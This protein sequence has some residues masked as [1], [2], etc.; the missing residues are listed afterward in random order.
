M[1]KIRRLQ[2]FSSLESAFPCTPI[3]PSTPLTCRTKLTDNVELRLNDG[4]DDQ[5]RDSLHRL[6]GERR[7]A[8]VPGAD[9][10]L[11]LVVAVNESDQIT[12]HDAVFV[13]QT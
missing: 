6:N 13:P 3:P 11:A 4:D 8:A 12:Q 5:L 9:H 7:W 10:E 1:N 2:P